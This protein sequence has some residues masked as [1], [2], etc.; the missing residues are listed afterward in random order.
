M[1]E[2]SNEEKVRYLKY[3]SG[4]S[5]LPDPN[6]IKFT[7]II[8]KSSCS[9]ADKRLPTATTCYFTLK[10]PPYSSYEILKEKLRYVINNCSEIDTDFTA[11]SRE[12]DN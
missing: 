6:E 3:V 1:N 11:S 4:R 7:H 10:L 9:D 8:A 5:K 12:F 2:F